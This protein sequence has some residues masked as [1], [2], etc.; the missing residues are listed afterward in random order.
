[1]YSELSALQTF[2]QHSVTRIDMISY[3]IMSIKRCFMCT[4]NRKCMLENPEVH[5]FVAVVLSKN[6]ISKTLTVQH[7]NTSLTTTFSRNINKK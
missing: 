7:S 2:L 6:F 5:C 1:M 3:C 4:G